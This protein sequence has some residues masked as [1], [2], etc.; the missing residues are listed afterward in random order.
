[1][2]SIRATLTRNDLDVMRPGKEKRPVEPLPAT[3]VLNGGGDRTRTCIA[4][5]PAVFKT[6]ALPLCDPSA[7]WL[8]E[9][10]ACAVSRP[11]R[12]NID[13]ASNCTRHTNR[14][15]SHRLTRTAYAR[16]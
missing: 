5:R 9:Y 6:A 14:A 13:I 8:R 7:P 10:S 16:H 12:R 2:P 11:N 4:F 1:M 3:F 15:R